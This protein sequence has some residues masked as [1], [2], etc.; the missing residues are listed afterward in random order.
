MVTSQGRAATSAT[1]VGVVTAFAVLLVAG[2]SSSSPQPP[3]PSSPSPTPSAPANAVADVLVAGHTHLQLTGDVTQTY[4]WDFV[5][6]SNQQDMSILTWG[7]GLDSFDLLAGPGALA[8]GRHK[9]SNELWI[10][11]VLDSIGASFVSD[12]GQCRITLS[13]VDGQSIEGGVSC[14]AVSTV[15]GNKTV[16]LV[17]TFSA[18][19]RE[20]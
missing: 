17:G 15:N 19:P 1:R 14:G 3:P 2:C 11:L 7:S 8:E 10:S 6:S 20:P 13:K 16:K 5:S 4:D 12:Q 9:S 18:G